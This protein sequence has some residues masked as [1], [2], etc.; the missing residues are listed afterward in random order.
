MSF[1]LCLSMIPIN[2]EFAIH[3]IVVTIKLKEST[4]VV[5]SVPMFPLPRYLQEILEVQY[6]TVPPHFYGSYILGYNELS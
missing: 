5:M 2:Y 6:C 1:L 3:G 4:K